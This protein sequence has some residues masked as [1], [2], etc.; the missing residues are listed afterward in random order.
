MKV[1]AIVILDVEDVTTWEDAY[2]AVFA[3]SGSCMSTW[4]GGKHYA[5]YFDK[6]VRVEGVRDTTTTPP[7]TG[8]MP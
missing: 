1:K 2:K 4:R 8:A 6:I 3:F 5:A 7:V